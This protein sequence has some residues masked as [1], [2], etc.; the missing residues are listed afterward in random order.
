MFTALACGVAVIFANY[1]GLLP[2]SEATNEYL[3]LGIGLLVGG[4]VLATKYH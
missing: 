1:L 4:F 2:G 3:F